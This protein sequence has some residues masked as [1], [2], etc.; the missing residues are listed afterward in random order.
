MIDAMGRRVKVSHPEKNPTLHKM[1][2]G[3]FCCGMREIRSES[4]RLFTPHPLFGL[5]LHKHRHCP[6]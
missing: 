1:K 3:A 2:G 6:V 4:T 5:R